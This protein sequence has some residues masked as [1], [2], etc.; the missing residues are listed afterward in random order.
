MSLRTTSLDSR[1]ASSTS[2]SL[3]FIEG[4]IYIPVTIVP[5]RVTVTEE[6][7]TSGA[8]DI[9]ERALFDPRA[10][11]PLVCRQ[12]GLDSSLGVYAIATVVAIYP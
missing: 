11:T 7:V 3:E 2:T 5:L 8:L 12:L 9:I 4:S 6:S 10:Y 1:L